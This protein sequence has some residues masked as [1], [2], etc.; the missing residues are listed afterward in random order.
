MS[1]LKASDVFHVED[2]PTSD[3]IRAMSHDD[4]I[5]F[6]KRG[7]PYAFHHGHG[8]EQAILMFQWHQRPDDWPQDYSRS[9]LL[10]PT[11]NLS[12]KAPQEQHKALEER[13]WH[14][15]AHKTRELLVKDY[16]TYEKKN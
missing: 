8:P 1:E 7:F 11:I 9:Y 14:M 2:I 3:E 5:E 15:A 6:V 13:L 4:R 16:E 12:P 10:S